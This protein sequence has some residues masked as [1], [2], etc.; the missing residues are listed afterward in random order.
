MKKFINAHKSLSILAGLFLCFCLIGAILFIRNIYGNYQAQQRIAH[1]LKLN[2]YTKI[3]PRSS[4]RKESTGPFSGISWYEYTF[5]TKQTL[6]ASYKYQNSLHKK[7]K[8]LTIKN[9]PIVYRVILTPPGTKIKHWTAEI[10][11][12]TNQALRDGNQTDYIQRLNED[13]R[14]S[15]NM[16]TQDSN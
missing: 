8:H 16:K 9:C 1:T 14:R 7:S 4:V 5:S 10:Y 6:V 15:L 13:S 3:V 11:L 2:G 12:D